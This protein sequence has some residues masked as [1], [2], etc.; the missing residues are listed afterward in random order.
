M[1]LKRKLVDQYGDIVIQSKK[2]ESEKKKLQEEIKEK[3]NTLGVK[4][5][6]GDV[7]KIELIPIIKKVVKPE[8]AYDVLG[9]KVFSVLRVSAEAFRDKVGKERFDELS[10]V[11]SETVRVEV[12]KL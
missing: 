8:I 3:M 4:I 9:E 6:E 12:N 10:E 11:E 7:Y 1:S 2:L 5:L